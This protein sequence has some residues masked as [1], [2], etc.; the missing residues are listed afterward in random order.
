MDNQK[1]TLN[2]DGTLEVPIQ[3]TK[4]CPTIMAPG[5][6]NRGSG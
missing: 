6:K 1:W 3:P 4:M 2:E 5:C